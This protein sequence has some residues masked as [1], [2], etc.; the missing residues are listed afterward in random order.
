MR[1]QQALLLLIILFSCKNKADKFNYE[2]SIASMVYQAQL[3]YLDNTLSRYARLSKEG[4]YYFEENDYLN[5]V[6][7]QFKI[8]IATGGAITQEDKNNFYNHFEKAFTTNSLID[9][10]IF[11]ELKELPIK[12]LSDVDLLR[13]YIK[14]NFVCLLLNTKLLPFNTWSTMAST[15]KSTI[16]Y[17]EY[18]EVALA[19]TAWNSAQPNEWFLVRKDNDSLNKENILDTLHQDETGV[20]Y[21]KTKKYKR[22]ENTHLLF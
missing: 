8:K 11:K 20:V 16:N 15:N 2:T 14:N 13:I 1:S 18:F 4:N 21:F 7:D 5:E 9:I 6:T 10:D 3:K 22:G 17:G 12:T 19:N